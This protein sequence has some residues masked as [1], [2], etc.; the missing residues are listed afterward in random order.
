MST[1]EEAYFVALVLEYGRQKGLSADR[2]KH[3]FQP[4]A[5]DGWFSIKKEKP[6]D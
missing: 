1:T 4:K 6:N 3:L 5:I 2:L